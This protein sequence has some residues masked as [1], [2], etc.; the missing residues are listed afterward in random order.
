MKQVVIVMNVDGVD[1]YLTIE[2]E[3]CVDYFLMN[4][5]QRDGGVDTK[6]EEQ[7]IGTEDL[8]NLRDAIDFIIG[9]KEQG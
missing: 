1:T 9:G 4:V 2:L 5:E 6:L 8:R 3:N 7:V